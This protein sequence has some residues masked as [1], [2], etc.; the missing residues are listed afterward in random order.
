MVVYHKIAEGVREAVY[1]RPISP[2][3]ELGYWFVIPSGYGNQGLNNV[4]FDG[5][6]FFV[7]WNNNTVNNEV[8]GRFVSPSGTRGTEIAVKTGGLPNNNPLTVPSMGTNYLIVWTEEVD[9]NVHN[10]DVFGPLVTP[11]GALSG[12][13][14]QYQHGP[15]PTFFAPY[16]LRWD[17]LPYFLDGYA[18]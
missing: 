17:E 4:A 6:N 7:I 1:G 13:K 3:G 16:R 11:A 9:A 12:G 5:T 14:N 18:K 8:R 2:S 10:W 15:G